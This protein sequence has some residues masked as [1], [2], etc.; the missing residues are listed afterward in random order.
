[1]NITRKWDMPSA[2]TFSVPT[3]GEFVKSYLRK[4]KVSVDPFASRIHF[5]RSSKL[6][7]VMGISG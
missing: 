4:S 5:T 6:I 2:D 3:I 7:P 1:M